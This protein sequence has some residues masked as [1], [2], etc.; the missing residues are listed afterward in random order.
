MSDKKR[1]YSSTEIAVKPVRLASA[2]PRRYSVYLLN[3]DYTPMSFVVEVLQE[4]FIETL[5]HEL[6][7]VINP[8]ANQ[9][10][11]NQ[12]KFLIKI[13]NLTSEQDQSDLIQVTKKIESLMKL[14]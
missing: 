10:Q 1:Y 14:S 4:F 11:T 7:K 5:I 3:D 9:D 13:L 12:I 8:I 2:P 6:I